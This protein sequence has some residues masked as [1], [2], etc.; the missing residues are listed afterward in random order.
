MRLDKHSPHRDFTKAEQNL[1]SKINRNFRCFEQLRLAP[2]LHLCHFGWSIKE[3]FGN[4]VARITIRFINLASELEKM[5]DFM[6]ASLDKAGPKQQ[7]YGLFI[8]TNTLYKK[9]TFGE[10]YPTKCEQFGMA[11]R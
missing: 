11:D 10:L 1:F 4:V 8:P 5:D 3:T 2:K 7:F 9:Q 6:T